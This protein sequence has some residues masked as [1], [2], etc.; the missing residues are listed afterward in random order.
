M[1]IVLPLGD[2]LLAK[3]YGFFFVTQG[4]AIGSLS[5]FA[6]GCALAIGQMFYPIDR[7]LPPISMQLCRN[8]TQ[9]NETFFYPPFEKHK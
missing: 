6:V 7:Q 2:S 5:G 3:T 4:A 9:R 8:E 1:A